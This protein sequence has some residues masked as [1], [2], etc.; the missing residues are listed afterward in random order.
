[1]VNETIEEFG[2]KLRGEDVLS[3]TMNS[4]AARVAVRPCHKSLTPPDP[5]VEP[6][7]DAVAD[8]IGEA[9]AET[10]GDVPAATDL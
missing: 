4:I 7:T 5:P 9:L 8:A 10:A 6:A 3:L 1:M 2:K